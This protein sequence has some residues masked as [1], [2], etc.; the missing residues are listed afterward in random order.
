MLARLGD[1]P[2]SHQIP[3]FM[4][5][6]EQALRIPEDD[7]LKPRPVSLN[8]D[9][10]LESSLK[11]PFIAKILKKTWFASVKNDAET[12]V[13]HVQKLKKNIS[14]SPIYKSSYNI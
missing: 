8:E 7:S 2:V 11:S 12:L 3:R 14:L 5:R 1:D 13:D 10:L 9:L 4:R 6:A